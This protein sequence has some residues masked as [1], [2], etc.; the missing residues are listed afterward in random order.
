[1]IC[2]RE[3]IHIL[4]SKETM[5]EAL[6]KLVIGDENDNEPDAD[7]EGT[8]EDHPC[9]PVKMITDGFHYF[10]KHNY[11][12]NPSVAR[13]Q[14]PTFLVF[15]CSDSRVSPSNVLN[16]Q[17]GEAFMVCNVAN[18][19]PVFN[20]LSYCGVGAVIEYAVKI[21]EVKNILIIGHSDCGGIK[22]LMNL[23]ADASTSNTDFIDNW[24]KIGLP[25][26]VKVLAEHP[27][28]CPEEQCKIC[29][30]EAVNLSLVNIQSY[31]YVRAAMANN[32]LTLRG[33]YYD[34]V[35]GSFQLWEVQYHITDPIYI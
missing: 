30:K 35:N 25:A 18:L 24:V 23:P 16:F 3:D 14:H 6:K 22:A 8:P 28:L 31:P 20:Q 27:N 33:G 7:L 1:M 21:L 11:E 15:A 17:P 26:K 19:V 32:S 9:D 13:G 34:F 10:M 29:E 4:I 2:I 12:Y 5:I